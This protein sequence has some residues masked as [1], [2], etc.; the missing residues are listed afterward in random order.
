MASFSQS[1]SNIKEGAFTA[2]AHAAGESVHQY[3]EEKQGASG[4]TGKQARLAL[5]FEGIAK[6]RRKGMV[7]NLKR[8]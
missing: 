1:V 4:K 5:T 6:N 7:K 3:A 8:G 2:K